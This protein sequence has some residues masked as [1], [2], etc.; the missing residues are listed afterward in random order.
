MTF[1]SMSVMPLAP[2]LGGLMLARLGGTASVAAL[3]VATACGAMIPT[4]SR[5][6]R[7]VP[8]PAEWPSSPSVPAASESALV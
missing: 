3:V 2:V 1:V 5:T 4:L 8:R 7:S 6:I